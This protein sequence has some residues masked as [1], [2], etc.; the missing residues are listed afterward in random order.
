MKARSVFQVTLCGALSLLG[1][2]AC[3]GDDDHAPLRSSYPPVDQ[4]IHDWCVD[5]C[6]NLE[7][8]EQRGSGCRSNCESWLTSL[9]D[10]C[11]DDI[12]TAFECEGTLSCEELEAYYN[13]GREHETCGAA[14]AAQAEACAP[15]EETPGCDAFCEVAVECDEEL[16][17]TCADRC[18]LNEAWYEAA[19]GTAC[20]EAFDELYACFGEGT[21]GDLQLLQS[22]NYVRQ[23]CEQLADRVDLEC[24]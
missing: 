7:C 17:P 14:L 8:E 13:E 4:E 15:E 19:H 21:C 10:Q 20:R 3:G 2:A 23:E 24:Y 1:F 9:D 6:D 5:F 16:A 18:V 12:R 22:S 11:G